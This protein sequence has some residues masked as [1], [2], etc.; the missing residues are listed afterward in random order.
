MH[1]GNRGGVHMFGKYILEKL[2]SE[3]EFEND[4]PSGDKDPLSTLMSSYPDLAELVQRKRVL[5]FGCGRGDQAAAMAHRF[6]SIVTGLDTNRRTLATA[7]KSHG[8]A[9]EFLD[10][11]PPGRTWDVVISLNAM[12]HYSDPVGALESMRRTVTFGGLVLVSF[13][14]PWWAPYGSHMQFFCRI[15]WLQLWFTEQTIMAVRARYRN[16]GARRFEDVESGLNK[17]SLAK[18]E[19]ILS[20]SN[21]SVIRLSYAGVKRMHWL[22]RVPVLRELGTVHVTSVLRKDA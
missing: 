1:A 19:R 22:T 3:A 6:S 11:I 4:T 18:F 8:A 16:D 13:G 15:P 10:K 2:S 9:V 5:D 20:A 21:L 12:E 17:M 7:V 14:P